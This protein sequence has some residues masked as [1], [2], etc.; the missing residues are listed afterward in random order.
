LVI[1]KSK[2]KPGLFKMW[3]LKK[4]ESLHLTRGNVQQKPAAHAKPAERKQYGHQSSLPD[5]LYPLSFAG[6]LTPLWVSPR[7]FFS[8]PWTLYSIGFVGVMVASACLP[9][10]EYIIGLWLNGITNL[11]K[12]SAQRE[13][14]GTDSAIWMLGPLLA[15]FFGSF[16]WF[17]CC[18]FMGGLLGDQDRL[19]D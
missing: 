18:E 6:P 3:S 19:I 11:Q 5:I 12:T 8:H 14:V 4:E 13:Q 17:T 9:V 2:P 16:T 10:F 7:C 15:A 1:L